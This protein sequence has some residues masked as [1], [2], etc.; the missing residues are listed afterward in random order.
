MKKLLVLSLLSLQLSGQTVWICGLTNGCS[1]LKLGAGL[2]LDTSVTPPVLTTT[3]ISTPGSGGG[4]T[5]WQS[6]TF[7][8]NCATNVRCTNSVPDVV[9]T[10]SKPVTGILLAFRALVQTETAD[11][12]KVAQPDGTWKI[13][14]GI[15]LKCATVVL[16]YQTL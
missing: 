6:D 2:K 11:Y 3:A 9:F 4:S 10:T 5:V 13:T 7:T 14:F 16:V 12:V 8:I 1:F 15:P